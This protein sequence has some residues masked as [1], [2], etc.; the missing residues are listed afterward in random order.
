MLWKNT[1]SPELLTILISL[2]AEPLFKNFILAGGTA[3]S[4][5]IGHRQSLDID[6]F[7]VDKQNNRNLLEYFQD[8]Y[9]NLE[10]LSYDSGILQII[11]NN[12]E[13]PP[14]SQDKIG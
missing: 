14:K 2:Q 12:I 7:T 5:Q 10:I 4:L 11:V 1:V 3:L 9:T 13:S 6:L 8:N